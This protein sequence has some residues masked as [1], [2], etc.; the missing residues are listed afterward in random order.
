MLLGGQLDFELG[1]YHDSPRTRANSR[2]REVRDVSPLAGR[3]KAVLIT[4]KN[5]EQFLGSSGNYP[6]RSYFPMKIQDS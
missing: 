4:A 1:V 5:V 2:G 3:S 6:R